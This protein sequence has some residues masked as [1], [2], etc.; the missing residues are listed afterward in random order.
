MK[1]RS[2]AAFTLIELLVVIAIIAILAAILFPVFAKARK[3]AQQSSCISNLKQIGVAM[4]MYLGDSDDRYPAWSPPGQR[5]FYSVED[6]TATVEIP[7]VNTTIAYQAKATISLQLDPYIKS[8]DVWAC[9]SD[10]GQYT[11]EVNNGGWGSIVSSKPFKEWRTL[12]APTKPIGVSYGYRG[13]NL[14]GGLIAQPDPNHWALAGASS[15]AVKLPSQR[16]MFWDHRGWHYGGK[17]DSPTDFHR[18]RVDILFLDGHV[19]AIP[20]DEFISGKDGSWGAP[21]DR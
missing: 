15:S 16:A 19:K 8:R 10:F 7:N 18:S 17:G 5:A 9:P 6:Y 2:G 21:Y 14:L 13:T 1:H 3:K 11:K 20:F 4:T 12:G